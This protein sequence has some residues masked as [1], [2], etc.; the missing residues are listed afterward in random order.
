[1]DMHWFYGFKV[2]L[3]QSFLAIILNYAQGT[4][5]ELELTI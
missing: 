3:F 5:K 2:S 1:M 4:T